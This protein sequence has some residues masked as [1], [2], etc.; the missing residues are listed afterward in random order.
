MEFQIKN[1]KLFKCIGSDEVIVVPEGVKGL[2]FQAIYNNN[3]V[4]E[5]ILPDGLERLDYKSI[6]YCQNL[7]K[8]SFPNNVI[9]VNVEYLCE[10]PNL[11]TLVFRGEH[12][13]WLMGSFKKC[14]LRKRVEISEKGL[15]ANVEGYSADQEFWS[16]FSARVKFYD[17]NGNQMRTPGDIAKEAEREKMKKEKERLATTAN[18]LQKEFLAAKKWIKK[19]GL[20]ADIA[21]ALPK[22]TV[23]TIDKTQFVLYAYGKQMEKDPIYHAKTYKTDYVE[24][25]ISRDADTVSE[26]LDKKVLRK[27]ALIATPKFVIPVMNENDDSPTYH[28]ID[29]TKKAFTDNKA[30]VE[31]KTKKE[32]QD[33]WLKPYPINLTMLLVY[34]RY[35]ADSDDINNLIKT[36]ENLMKNWVIPGRVTAIAIRSA[37]LLNETKEAIAYIDKCGLL[38]VYATMRGKKEKEIR[39][40]ITSDTGLKSD[41]SLGFDL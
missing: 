18:P 27:A 25:A 36:S 4:K 30:T 16:I 37:L 11:Q 10:C 17:H 35:F 39:D 6:S 29:L 32:I 5:I 8:I 9:D 2:A 20:E 28:E 34:C 33:S 24:V 41:G 21:K 22:A 26:S 13:T 1:E 19:Q 12:Y 3:T 38:K 40:I 15:V 23:D 31:K 7:E 14:P